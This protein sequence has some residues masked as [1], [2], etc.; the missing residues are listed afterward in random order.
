MNKWNWLIIAFKDEFSRESFCNGQIG[1]AHNLKRSHSLVSKVGSRWSSF[2]GW[3]TAPNVNLMICWFLLLFTSLLFAIS[4]NFCSNDFG[5]DHVLTFCHSLIM[6]L[7]F[8]WHW[9][10]RVWWHDKLIKGVAM[11]IPSYLR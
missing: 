11:Q 6:H 5:V 2:L 3:K 8:L 4:N 9:Q 7:L 10:W 1:I